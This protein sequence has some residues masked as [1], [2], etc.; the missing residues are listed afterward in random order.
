MWQRCYTARSL[1][2][3]GPNV[4]ANHYF[5]N[6]WKCGASIAEHQVHLGKSVSPLDTRLMVTALVL[7]GFLS[8]SALR[9]E[10]IFACA[11]LGMQC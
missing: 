10:F 1:S 9:Q 4:S 3:S 2:E 5:E 7:L 8:G 11:L 6:S